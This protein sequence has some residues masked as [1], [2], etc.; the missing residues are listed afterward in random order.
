MLKAFFYAI[1]Y[2]Y[3]IAYS[4]T[5]AYFYAIVYF[6]AFSCKKESIHCCVLINR[7][8]VAYLD[9]LRPIWTNLN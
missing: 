7:K 9:Q 2:F 6:Y 8:R 3:D 4:Y 5:I 1:P